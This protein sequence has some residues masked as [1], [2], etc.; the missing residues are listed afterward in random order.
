M[1]L[2]SLSFFF[3]AHNEVEN[4]LPMVREALEVLPRC[5]ES[6]EVIIVDDGSTDGTGELADDLAA[7]NPGLVRAVHNWPN[8]GY[9]GAVRRGFDESTMEWVFFTDGDRQFRLDELG[10][11]FEGASEYDLIIGYRTSRRD[12]FHRLVNAKLYALLIRILFGLK[13]RDIDCAYKLI[14]RKV[15]ESIRLQ[16]EGALMTAELLIKAEAAGF[17]RKEKGVTHYPRT[18]GAQSG[19]NLKVILR[20]F[21]ELASNYRQIKAN[22]RK[23]P[24]RMTSSR[25]QPAL[26]T[27]R[28]QSS[29][30]GKR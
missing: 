10:R 4:L 23:G 25:G 26:V 9:G 30:R 2:K 27:D 14:R 22:Q 8:R 7:R 3:P 21:A 5:A 15:L 20:M 13:V 24:G 29:T 12:P 18:A 11:F 17:V 1:K 19:A 6:F 28:D 16:S